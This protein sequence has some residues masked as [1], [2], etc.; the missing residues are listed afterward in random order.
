M[1]LFTLLSVLSLR[2]V[3]RRI[4]R[5]RRRLAR[6]A[7]STRIGPLLFIWSVENGQRMHAGFAQPVARKDWS[8]T[9]HAHVTLLRFYE[10]PELTGANT[11]KKSL[12]LSERLTALTNLRN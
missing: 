11:G 5:S 6:V 8:L 10:L 1:N 4:S 9:R 7:V 2:S 3:R 12:S